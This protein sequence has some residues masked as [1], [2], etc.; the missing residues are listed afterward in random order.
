MQSG[1]TNTFVL[2]FLNTHRLTFTNTIDVVALTAGTNATPGVKNTTQGIPISQVYTDTSI[3]GSPR[4]TLAFTST[5]GQSYQV[6]YSDDGLQTWQL[7]S[8]VTATSTWT[9]WTEVLPP[10]QGSRFFKVIP[11]SNNP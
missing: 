6:F 10:A 11:F 5:P 3:G 4:F 1:T 8:T 7:A 2:Q 9:I